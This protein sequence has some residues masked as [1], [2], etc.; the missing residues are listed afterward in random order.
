MEVN[1]TDAT[2][3]DIKDADI[4]RINSPI[5][6]VLARAIVSTGQSIGQVFMP[7]HWSDQFASM[8]RT[9]SLIEA[10]TD[11]YSRQ[12][13]FKNQPVSIQRFAAN[14]YAFLI[15]RNEP[16]L[17]SFNDIEYWASSP[18]DNGWRTEIASLLTTEQLKEHLRPLS[19][20][21]H[22]EKDY[23]RL[24]YQNLNERRH[25]W[26][27]LNNELQVLL[28]IGSKPVQISRSWAT[29]LTNNTYSS[30][31]E[32]WKLMA[33]RAP[34]DQPDKGAIVCSCFGVGDKEIAREIRSGCCTS[35]DEIGRKLSAG[36]N[37]GSCRNEIG[38]L[39]KQNR[40]AAK[41][42]SHETYE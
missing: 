28:Y 30:M 2:I 23:Q 3:H 27:N 31:A 20:S 21:F 42:P 36:T 7:M 5:G 26:F 10:R 39:L 41:Q 8:A 12:P 11:P 9:D 17:R 32:R 14:S 18:I 38:V 16:E 4:V 40:V 22:P 29:T 19:C 35:V 34:T 25:A 33:G 1:P 13:A 24:D 37:C 15:T 6:T